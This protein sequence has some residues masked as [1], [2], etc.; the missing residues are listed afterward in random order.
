MLK[1]GCPIARIVFPGHPPGSEIHIWKAR[2]TDDTLVCGY[3]KKYSIPQHLPGGE[4]G[5]S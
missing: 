1:D 5:R 3:G 4:L 2:I